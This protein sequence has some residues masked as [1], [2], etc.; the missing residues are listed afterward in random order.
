MGSPLH[1]PLAGEV[2]DERREAGAEREAGKAQAPH[3]GR[4]ETQAQA[5]RPARGGSRPGL[6]D[7]WPISSVRSISR[8][9]ARAYQRVLER[10]DE[11]HDGSIPTDH[12]LAEYLSELYDQGQAPNS[13]ALVVSAVRFR[14]KLQGL[15]SPVGPVTTR[16]LAGIRRAGKDRR[17]GQVQG[18]AGSQP[19]TRPPRWPAATARICAAFGTPP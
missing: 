17:Q 18:V 12:G 8:N 4:K 2:A 15:D 5:A 14:A 7:R 11:R 1:A 16:A 9:T 10:L 3:P 19:R 13:I 6:P